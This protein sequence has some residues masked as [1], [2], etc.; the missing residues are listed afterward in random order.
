MARQWTPEETAEFVDYAR[1]SF[2]AEDRKNLE[3]KLRGG[4]EHGIIAQIPDEKLKDRFQKHAGRSL[5]GRLSPNLDDAIGECVDELWH[6]EEKMA[7]IVQEALENATESYERVKSRGFKDGLSLTPDVDKQLIATAWKHAFTKS[8][9]KY[10][11]PRIQ[12]MC[13]RRATDGSL[14]AISEEEYNDL[15]GETIFAIMNGGI[16]IV[17][18]YASVNVATMMRE[19]ELMQF[20]GVFK[21]NTEDNS[22]YQNCSTVWLKSEHLMPQHQKEC[23]KVVEKI[24]RMPFELCKK[25]KIMLQVISYVR[26]LLIT[27]ENSKIKK[28]C[29]TL[30]CG[31]M[32]TLLYVAGVQ[33]REDVHLDI[34]VDGVTQR[35]KL[36]PDMLIVLRNN[37]S[38]EL[39]PL[40]GKVFI[41][42]AWITGAK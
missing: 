38:Y 25:C 18:D 28:H 30:E 39:K 7:A 21:K 26:V 42:S 12:E 33:S 29:E 15:E 13:A 11:V 14:C 27:G 8:I 31:V 22:V 6:S 37:V 1:R 4:A 10:T 19:M 5:H 17:K 24:K 34:D 23:L 9:I 20:N 36:E 32:F 2:N 40:D 35:I 41:V 16:A 3:N